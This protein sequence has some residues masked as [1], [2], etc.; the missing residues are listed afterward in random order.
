MEKRKIK[1]FFF[2]K[3]TFELSYLCLRAIKS[4]ASIVQHRSA[5]IA[6]FV[7]HQGHRVEPPQKKIKAKEKKERGKKTNGDKFLNK[8]ESLSNPMEQ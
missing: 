1:T 7:G 2:S 4:C 8:I 6:L 5:T 3:F